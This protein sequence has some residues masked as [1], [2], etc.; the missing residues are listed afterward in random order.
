MSIA[1][2]YPGRLTSTCDLQARLLKRLNSTYQKQSHGPLQMLQ[3]PACLCCVVHCWTWP[4]S[5][6]QKALCQQPWHACR[7][8]LLLGAAWS[9]CSQLRKPWA[10]SQPLPFPAGLFN[11]FKVPL[12]TPDVRN[13]ACPTCHVSLFMPAPAS[14]CTHCLDALVQLSAVHLH[15]D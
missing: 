9:S 14:N 10:L 4:L 7:L 3:A 2:V 6:W 13:V 1:S 11:F 15:F 8:L 12:V 5:T